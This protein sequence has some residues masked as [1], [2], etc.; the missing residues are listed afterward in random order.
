LE[1]SAARHEESTRARLE[2]RSE[3]DAQAQP[4]GAAGVYPVL[5]VARDQAPEIGV[6]RH[7]RDRKQARRFWIDINGKA[8]E[9]GERSVRGRYQRMIEDIRD[10]RPYF[11]NVSPLADEQIYYV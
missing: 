4:D 6:A 3:R 2:A 5:R 1:E 10:V 7:A 8:S 11:M 9:I